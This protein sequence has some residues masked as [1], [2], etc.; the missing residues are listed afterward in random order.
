M[1]LYDAI[2]LVVEDEADSRELIQ[3]L[4]GYHGIQP[5]TVPTAEDALDQLNTLMPHLMIIDLS[6]P[7]MDG[8]SLM[9]RLLADDRYRQTKCVAITA[10]HRPGLAAE[11]LEAGFDAYFSKPLDATSFVRELDVILNT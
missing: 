1:N 6:L 2:I 4:L 8:W 11:A 10:Y 9:Q 3:G 7:E 5:V